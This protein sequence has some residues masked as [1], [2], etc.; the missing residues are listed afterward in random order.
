MKHR[1]REKRIEAC[2]GAFP[3]DHPSAVLP[4][5]PGKRPLGLEA[6]DVLFQGTPTRF[7]VFPDSFGDLGA[8]TPFAKALTQVFGI[9][10]LIRGQHRESFAWSAPLT[11]A[12]VERVQ[13]WED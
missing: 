11:R 10:A 6:R 7:S 5:E 4:L 3:A 12:D 2:R 9:I 1:Y 8:D 13:Q